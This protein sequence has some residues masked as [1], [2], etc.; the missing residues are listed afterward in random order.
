MARRKPTRTIA[1]VPRKAK[2]ALPVAMSWAN[3]W[4][5]VV[6]RFGWPGMLV[7]LA[8]TFI[9]SF[10]S[11]EQKHQFVDLYILGKG[12]G[13]AWPIISLGVLFVAAAAAQKKVYDRKIALLETELARIGNEKSLLQQ[14]LTDQQLQRTAAL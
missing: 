2:S 3:F 11:A 14:E 10:A 12:I 4:A 13:H 9:F 8:A 1:A 6:D 5:S 7:L